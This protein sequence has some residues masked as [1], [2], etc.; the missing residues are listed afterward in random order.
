MGENG[1]PESGVKN[2]KELSSISLKLQLTCILPNEFVK[3]EGHLPMPM[4]SLSE[5][6]EE[7]ED[8][9]VLEISEFV[10][11]ELLS[12]AGPISG[13]REVSKPPVSPALIEKLVMIPDCSSR[14]DRCSTAEPQRRHEENEAD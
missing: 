13:S 9:E 5:I 10:D 8:E 7:E 4:P 11:P 2:D 1:L 12:G 3:K 14:E 6:S